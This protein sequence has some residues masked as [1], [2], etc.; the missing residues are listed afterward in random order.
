MQNKPF[1]KVQSAQG[2]YSNNGGNGSQNGPNAILSPTEYDAANKH[3]K[4]RFIYALANSLGTKITV[5]TA[6]SDKITG[7]LQSISDVND[8]IPSLILKYPT[9][10]GHV[11]DDEFLMIPESSIS[12]MTCENLDFTPKASASSASASASVASSTS[13]SSAH[14][15]SAARRGFRIDTDISSND[16]YRERE[17]DL[18]KWVPEEDDST[19]L[20]AA[21]EEEKFSDANKWDQFKTNKDKFG[22]DAKF[23]E[24]DYTVKLNVSN[25][26]F[27]ERMKF[28]ETVSREILSQSSN[29]NLHIAE[30]RGKLVDAENID[31]EDKYSGVLRDNAES[32]KKLMNML[33]TN[34]PDSF[35]KPAPAAAAAAAASTTVAAPSNKLSGQYIPPNQRNAQTQKDVSSTAGTKR[36]PQAPVSSTTPVAT[37]PSAAATP[38]QLPEK[39]ATTQQTKD[40]S[41]KSANNEPAPSAKKSAAAVPK[42]PAAIPA[43]LTLSAPSTTSTIPTNSAN[44]STSTATPATSTTQHAQKSQTQAH[45][46]GTQTPQLSTQQNGVPSKQKSPQLQKQNFTD[47][48]LDQNQNQN[49]HQQ[50]PHQPHQSHQPHQIHQQHQHQQGIPQQLPPQMQQQQQQQQHMMRNQQFG[51]QPRS[52]IGSQQQYGSPSMQYRNHHNGSNHSSSQ[53]NQNYANS[54]N[55]NAN[56]NQRMKKSSPQF[57]FS[58]RPS[59]KAPRGSV[60]KDRFNI[61]LSAKKEYKSNSANVTIDIIP[62]VPSFHTSPSW[63]ETTSESYSEIFTK[64]NNSHPNMHMQQSVYMHPQ[65]YPQNHQPYMGFQVQPPYYFPIVPSYPVYLPNVAFPMMGGNQGMDKVYPNH[66]RHGNNY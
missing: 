26:K 59:D 32:E 2:S 43:T 66:A 7:I 29:G 39:P 23:D 25:P 17:R 52:N 22:I 41:K 1:P 61:L 3:M 64:E 15:H 11:Y 16:T 34:K 54:N 58:H 42:K 49:Q 14:N 57:L 30:E 9:R 51:Y 38:V 21:L 56:A 47:P 19:S 18:Q 4:D 60:L 35:S 33:K 46:P 28:A 62:M 50:Q 65:A 6:N 31:E 55:V 63:P 10:A 24:N 13:S 8:T 44:S 20:G 36:L 37:T 48:T 12:M 40:T 5:T 53:Y 27:K 45:Q